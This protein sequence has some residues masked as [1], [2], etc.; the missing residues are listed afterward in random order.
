MGPRRSAIG[1]N[2]TPHYMVAGSRPWNVVLFDDVISKEPGDWVFVSKPSELSIERV[3]EFAPTFIFFLHWS[4]KVPSEIFENYECIGFH[5]SDLPYGR[6]GSPLQNLISRGHRDTILTAVKLVEEF[7]AGPF[8]AKEPLSLQGSA[9]EIYIRAG[10]LSASM[11]S[12]I[13]QNGPEPRLQEGEPVVFRRRTQAE[14]QIQPQTSMEDLYNFIRMLDAEGYPKAFLEH[15]G[16]RM[17]FTGAALLDGE[18]KANVS[19]TLTGEKS[20]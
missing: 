12:S 16:Y 7:D 5:M 18:V 9:E 2:K 19:I 6:G 20:N 13:I 14:S 10:N 4:W 3:M 17:E 15:E 11:I 8:Y 1:L